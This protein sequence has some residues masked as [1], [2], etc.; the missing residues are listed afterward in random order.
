MYNSYNHIRVG[1]VRERK[2]AFLF[3]CF[4]LGNGLEHAIFQLIFICFIYLYSLNYFWPFQNM[5]YFEYIFLVEAFWSWK[6]LRNYL[7]TVCWGARWRSKFWKNQAEVVRNLAIEIFFTERKGTFYGGQVGG[8]KF[9][10]LNK[11]V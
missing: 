8:T 5:L 2:T 3:V 1:E 9:T 4:G 7:F 10:V 11:S 6:K